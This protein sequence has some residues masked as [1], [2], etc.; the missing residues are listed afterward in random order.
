MGTISLGLLLGAG[1]LLEH[2][3]VSLGKQIAFTGL[4]IKNAPT[5]LPGAG[6]TKCVNWLFDKNAAL[7][8]RKGLD[9]WNSTTFPSAVDYLGSY[10]TPAGN[11]YYLVSTKDS[12]WFVLDYEIDFSNYIIDS[13]KLSKG[14]VDCYASSDLVHVGDVDSNY[15]WRSLFGAGVDLLFKIG[16]RDSEYR[17]IAI[18]E[19]T[20]L[21]LDS[22][23]WAGADSSYYISVD[24]YRINDATV[25]NS[26]FIM[27]TT[28]GLM[29]YDGD[30]ANFG[31][32]LAFDTAT[33]ASGYPIY[34]AYHGRLD[35]GNVDPGNANVIC[36]A[37]NPYLSDT[38]TQATE[39]QGHY[40]IMQYP[41]SLWQGG[42]GSLF[43]HGAAFRPDADSIAQVCFYTA[44][45]DSST[46]I[47]FLCDSIE[48]D[49]FYFGLGDNIIYVDRFYPA[50]SM[51]AWD[52]TRFETGDWILTIPSCDTCGTPT[53]NTNYFS[54][55]GMLHYVNSGDTAFYACDGPFTS[56]YADT[57]TVMAMRMPKESSPSGNYKCLAT[58]K[59]RL[60]TVRADAPDFLK[61]SPP[62]YPDSIDAYQVIGLDITNGDRIE[63]MAVLY[64]NLYI[65]TR[66]TIHQ[67]SGDPS[68]PSAT[69]GRLF[70]GVGI[71]APKAFVV[72][73]GRMLLCHETGFYLFDGSRPY[74]I[75][76]SIRPI[77]SDSINWTAAQDVMCA[78]YF[79]RHL[80]ISYPSGTAAANNRTL[81]YNVDDGRWGNISF[82]AGAYHKITNPNDTNRFLVGSADTG[83][84]YVYKGFTDDGTGITA[85]YETGWSDF[86]SQID[87]Q[88]QGLHVVFDKSAACSLTVNLYRNDT[89]VATVIIDTLTYSQSFQD[90]HKNVAD[91]D[92]IAR[93]FKV[94]LELNSSKDDGWISD[95]TLEIV[96]TGE[97]H[98][99]R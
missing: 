38:T 65:F 91:M 69:L 37:I 3:H 89:I 97:K 14:T 19:D 79:D 25:S 74:P 23:L 86:G 42:S 27:A 70:D 95:L 18:Y 72:F 33:A 30:G 51:A 43:T 49:T 8:V 94:G 90:K 82:V 87:K 12:T 36:C 48:V 71:S 46:A 9:Q 88:V 99:D 76:E 24:D 31:D 16:N 20:L 78:G 56:T 77:I 11:A 57:I 59:D 41:I 58:Y 7:H 93:L 61:Y 96:E 13:W 26:K 98:Y 22:V 67:L 45:I 40:F 32:T 34:S 55:P 54:I 73:E 39:T 85:Q 10:V 80:W 52:S 28:Q 66:N 17:I 75:S 4:D 35:W 84:V 29:W 6:A 63:R 83:A 64:D 62:F 60:F 81:V 21:R 47:T 2:S 44:S 68:S 92:A 53:R 5:A 15:H 50:D 1:V